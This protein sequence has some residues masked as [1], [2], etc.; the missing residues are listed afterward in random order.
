MIFKFII[1]SERHYKQYIS[2]IKLHISFNICINEKIDK[3]IM[4]I[5]YFHVNNF[6]MINLNNSKTIKYEYDIYF[7][8]NKL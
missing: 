1:N 5:I 3:N 6:I 8:S 7:I 2:N 4:T